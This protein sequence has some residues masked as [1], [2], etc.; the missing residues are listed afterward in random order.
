M[1]DDRQEILKI[2][3][4]V[5]TEKVLSMIICHLAVIIKVIE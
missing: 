2:S 5:T 1:P 3:K 4:N